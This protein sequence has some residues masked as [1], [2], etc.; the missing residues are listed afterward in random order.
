MGV[1]LAASSLNERRI[2]RIS[3]LSKL[4]MFKRLSTVI[5]RTVTQRPLKTTQQ[6]TRATLQHLTLLSMETK[7]SPTK[8][9][10]NIISWK[11]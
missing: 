3:Q 10:T 9:Q 11:R 7:P 1:D 8:R 6:R 4:L 5:S 2:D